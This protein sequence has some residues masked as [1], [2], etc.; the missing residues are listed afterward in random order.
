MKEEEPDMCECTCNQ[1]TE[2][3]ECHISFKEK[4]NQ[5]IK[6]VDDLKKKETTLEVV[7]KLNRELNPDS[8][9]NFILISDGYNELISFNDYTLWES[10]EDDRKYNETTDEYEDLFNFIKSEFKKHINNLYIL[11]KTIN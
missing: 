10:V 5:L 6:F 9:F 2:N 11:S 3:C 7:Q 4:H 8:E 1:T